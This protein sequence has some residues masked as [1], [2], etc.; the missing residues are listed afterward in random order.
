MASMKDLAESRAAVMN[1][2]PRKLRVKPG[3]NA[4]DL[5]TPENVEHIE[6]LASS[7]A[8]DGVKKPLEIFLD[9][10]DV[11]VSDG[12]CR[13]AAT[14]LAIER[15]ADIRTVPCLSE[16]RGTNDIDR[17]LNQNISNS[18]KR[19]TPLEEG[20]NI[21]RAIALGATIKDVAA[22]L[23]KSET[24]VAQSLD[25]QAAPAEI[26]ELV[27]KGEVSAT[28]AAKTIRREGSAG[29]ETI[30][31]AVANA[32]AAGKDR[33][34]E[35]HVEAQAEADYNERTNPVDDMKIRDKGD[36][37]G[38]TIGRTEY[39]MSKSQWR[40]LCDRIEQAI[41]PQQNDEAAE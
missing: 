14:M 23:G 3:L 7:I 24:Y 16:S 26:H 27:R 17:I 36:A 19:L 4:R 12:H 25:F 5:D 29:A 8:Q 6:W 10:D 33:A 22:K 30:K 37:L 21:K 13:L 11:F 2:D 20:H 41:N 15:G 38:V 32:K 34:T 35:K 28:L 31:K 18:G 1:F 39:T 9:G 40:R